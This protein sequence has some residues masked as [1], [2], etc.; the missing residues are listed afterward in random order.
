LGGVI[1]DLSVDDTLEGFAALSGYD[2]KKINQLYTLSPEFLLYEKGMIDDDEFRTFIRKILGVN[3]ASIDIDNAWNA[4]IR[5]LPLNKLQLLEKLKADYNV[6]LLSN[7]NA[8]HLTYINGTILPAV[9]GDASSLDTY[10][11][12]AYYSHLMKKRKPDA[13]IFEE[14]LAESNILASETLFLDDNRDNITGA[15]KVGIKTAFVDTPNFIL[16]YFDEH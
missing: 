11:H 4:M 10:F 5:G 12:R 16:D 6:L 1:I 14:V 3:A 8:I 15:G 2:R 9:V 13:E 7:T